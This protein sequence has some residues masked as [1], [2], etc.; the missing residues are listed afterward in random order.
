M[1]IVARHVLESPF[2]MIGSVP[3]LV[4]RIRAM[5]RRW[6]INSLLVGWLDED[7]IGEFTPVVDQLS[8]T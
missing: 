6:G 5:R 7:G 8:E 2:S 3:D 1:A 4:D